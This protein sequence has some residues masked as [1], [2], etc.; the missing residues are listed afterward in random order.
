MIYLFGIIICLFLSV[1]TDFNSLFHIHCSFSF[2]FRLIYFTVHISP[3]SH[4]KATLH[5]T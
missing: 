4:Y 1:L 5:L 3:K 2:Y